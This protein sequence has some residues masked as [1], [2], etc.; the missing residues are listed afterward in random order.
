MAV[1]QH[2][3]QVVKLV[4]CFSLRDAGGKRE[5][6]CVEQL[7]FLGNGLPAIVTSQVID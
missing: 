6:D 3:L 7:F 5:S 2:A 4:Q 1:K